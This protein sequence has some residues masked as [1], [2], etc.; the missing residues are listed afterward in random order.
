MQTFYMGF[1]YNLYSDLLKRIFNCEAIRSSYLKPALSELRQQPL[2]PLH[3]H[4]FISIKSNGVQALPVVMRD[5]FH[6][7]TQA[8]LRLRLRAA[9]S[10]SYAHCKL[11]I[12]RTTAGFERGREAD[13]AGVATT[14]GVSKAVQLFKPFVLLGAYSRLD[15]SILASATLILCGS[16]PY[17]NKKFSFSLVGYLCDG[18][19][20][21]SI[22]V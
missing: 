20:Q 2:H 3:K 9:S 5:G 19:R 18:N 22:Q 21:N 7:S 10:V 15:V 1:Y 13:G 6:C 12:P 17:H 11:I 4:L 14:W 16:L 8:P